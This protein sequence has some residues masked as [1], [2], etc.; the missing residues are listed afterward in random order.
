M[1]DDERD[2]RV[3]LETEAE[4]APRPQGLRRA[5][6]RRAM[7]RRIG[8]VALPVLL[9]ASVAWVA[10]ASPFGARTPEVVGSGPG[11]FQGDLFYEEVPEQTRA[12]IFAF[13]ALAHTGLMDPYG[14]RS[15]NWTYRDDTTETEG[16]WRVGFAAIDCAPANNTQ[17]CTGMSG[18]DPND[19]NALTDTYLLVTLNDGQWEVLAV[20]GNMPPDEQER[21]VG[22]S[23]PDERE[24]SHWDFASVGLWRFAG[25]PSVAMTPI[26]VGPYP[27]EARGNVC[28]VIA[29]DD[30]G[31]PV[32]KTFVFYEGPPDRPF[33]RGGWV[34]GGGAQLPDE[35]IDAEVTCE[36]YTGPGWE[37]DG[38]PD[39][40]QG[41]G[42]VRGVSVQVKWIGD[43]RFTA[44]YECHA[45]LVDDEGEVVWEKTDRRSPI[46]SPNLKKYP[47]R[48]ALF[49]SAR[50]PV[51]A[52]EVGEVTC[53]TL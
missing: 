18:E 34:R 8:V 48:T 44:A 33:E 6:F 47:Y 49:L 39:L 29:V 9:L 19:G 37:I 53:R 30:E 26:W 10:I 28:E 36:Q 40:V 21:V 25:R 16:S 20:E 12:E 15:Y 7:G 27:T 24:P 17:T 1:S 51:D 46:T 5:T 43:E 22:Y 41:P 11:P 2:I 13:R 31:G 32:G 3:L 4:R 14:A 42:G 23:L 35:A 52:Q 50:E 38:E 45:T